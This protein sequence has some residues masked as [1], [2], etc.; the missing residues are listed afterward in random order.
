MGPVEDI[1]EIIVMSLVIKKS[2]VVVVVVKK[3]HT[4]LQGTTIMKR[5]GP[6][7][8]ANKNEAGQEQ[9]F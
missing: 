5:V 8:A 6:H 1:S 3:V 7:R 2:F 4:V 9:D